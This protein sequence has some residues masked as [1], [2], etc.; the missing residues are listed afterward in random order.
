MAFATTAAVDE[1]AG[2]AFAGFVTVR[3]P[4]RLAC[5][6]D[7]VAAPRLTWSLAVAPVVFGLRTVEVVETIAVR[8]L[9]AVAVCNQRG[10]NAVAGTVQNLAIRAGQLALC[11]R[12]IAATT[13]LWV[14]ATAIRSNTPGKI[15]TSDLRIRSPLLYPTELPGQVRAL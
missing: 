14:N 10:R 13:R 6:A 9:I 11:L 2:R 8:M 7:A 4:R 12:A 15:R 1:I 3:A 5:S